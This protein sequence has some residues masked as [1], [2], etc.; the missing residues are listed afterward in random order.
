MIKRVIHVCK[1][2]IGGGIGIHEDICVHENAS[3]VIKTGSGSGTHDLKYRVGKNSYTIHVSNLGCGTLHNIPTYFP[4]RY[5]FTVEP[6]LKELDTLKQKKINPAPLGLVYVDEKA[7]AVLPYHTIL[8][9]I[10]AMAAKDVSGTCGSGSG[11]AYRYAIEKPDLAIYVGDFK[12]TK[13]LKSK[14]ISLRSS[15]RMW[16]RHFTADSFKEEAD[17]KR[18]LKYQEILLDPKD[19]QLELMVSALR[20][21]GARLRYRTLPEILKMFDGTAIV[22]MSHGILADS[23][24]GFQPYVCDFRTIPQVFDKQLRAAGFRGKISHYI[25][26]RAYQYR[27]GPGPMP[28]KNDKYEALLCAGRKKESNRWRGVARYG[29][30]DIPLL[31]YSIECCGGPSKVDGLCITCFDHVMSRCSSWDICE[32]YRPIGSEGLI[33]PYTTKLNTELLNTVLPFV[34][35]FDFPEDKAAFKDKKVLFNFV[36]SRLAMCGLDV[37]LKLLSCSS[38]PQRK[39]RYEDYHIDKPQEA[40]KSEG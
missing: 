1:A 17:K 21:L 35:N 24:L 10:L 15:V 16:L 18:F 26:H 6:F 23:E 11:K 36:E 14:L 40:A 37:P 30:L 32:A 12:S 34:V 25:V 4:E 28:T 3:I 29:Y 27:H 5:L 19:E 20:A 8:S 2:G 39:Y 22:E 33:L 9:R 13:V 38:S 7:I 31:A